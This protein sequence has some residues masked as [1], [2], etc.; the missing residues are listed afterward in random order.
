VGG[1][2]TLRFSTNFAAYFGNGTREAHIYCDSL[3]GSHKVPDRSLRLEVK[4]Q[5][6]SVSLYVCSYRFDQSDKIRYDDPCGV[7][8]VSMGQPRPQPK[9][10]GFT[11]QIFCPHSVHSAVDLDFLPF[12]RYS[13]IGI[14]VRHNSYCSIMSGLQ[15]PD[16]EFRGAEPYD[17]P[18]IIML[19]ILFRTPRSIERGGAAADTPNLSSPT[20]IILSMSMSGLCRTVSAIDKS[21]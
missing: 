9:G 19:H 2:K 8:C 15:S 16:V 4:V 6:S 5:F 20:C 11:G 10:R 18:R 3:A 14:K 1:K 21:V 12:L 7:G 13:P 17:S